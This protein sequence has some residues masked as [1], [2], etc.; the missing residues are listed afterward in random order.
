VRFREKKKRKYWPVSAALR[1][2]RGKDRPVKGTYA[3]A[4]VREAV[5]MSL[6]WRHRL[7]FFL[8]ISFVRP[9]PCISM[10]QSGD[11]WSVLAYKRK[12]KKEIP[13]L[14]AQ[15]GSVDTLHFLCLQSM[16]T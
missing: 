10:P 3:V 5:A 7:S 13:R 14:G 4:P 12:R 11:R 1:P 6:R 9:G 16:G 15:K 2:L 8:F